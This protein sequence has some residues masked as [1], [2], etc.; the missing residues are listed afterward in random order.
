[1]RTCHPEFPTFSTIAT[2][3]KNAYNN[4]CLVLPNGQSRNVWLSNC[5][6]NYTDMDLLF[7]DKFNWCRHKPS[8][9]SLGTV[10]RECNTISGSSN[11]CEKLCS[12]CERGHA[13]HYLEQ[14]IKCDCQFHFCCEIQCRICTERRTYYACSSR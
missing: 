13:E 9:G 3:L 14:D 2:T 7:R 10:G 12:H 11:S 4:A 1:M 5:S 8:I 6:R